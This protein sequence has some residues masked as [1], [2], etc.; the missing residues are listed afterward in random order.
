MSSKNIIV[1]GAN[2]A[3][4]GAEAMLMTVHTELSKRLSN[5][6]FFM[7]C[8]DFESPLAISSGFTPICPPKPNLYWKIYWKLFGIKGKAYK[9]LTGRPNPYKDRI[10]MESVKQAVQQPDFTINVS[11]FAFGDDWGVGMVKESLKLVKYTKQKGGKYIFMPQAWGPFT[12]SALRHATLKML[13]NSFLFHARDK[14]SR[15]HLGDLWKLDKSQI[16][17]IP[18]IAFIFN[19][20][21]QLDSVESIIEEGK[22]K[23]KKIVAIT[24]NLRVFERSFEKNGDNSYL[25][26][27]EQLIKYIIRKGG[28]HVLLVPNEIK[29]GG[30]DPRDDRKVI[31]ILKDRIGIDDSCTYVEEYYSAGQVKNIIGKCDF[32][33]SSRYHSLIFALSQNIPSMA[34]SWSHKYSELFSLFDMEEF[35]LEKEQMNIDTMVERFEHLLKNSERI[36]EKIGLGSTKIKQQI[37]E[38]FDKLI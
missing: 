13:K 18:D 37:H 14:I 7:I 11:G 23:G 27:L 6:K 24:P 9:F 35:V 38:L 12:S 21:N 26:V 31:K 25:L 34:I 10:F 15:D 30:A 4:K 2:F 19:S 16:A 3:N 28:F 22:V 5:P 1:V 17:M 8:H 33:I 32:V 20:E 36:S 29:P